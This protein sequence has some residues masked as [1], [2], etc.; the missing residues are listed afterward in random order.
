MTDVL[1]AIVAGYCA[2]LSTTAAI[3]IGIK[4]LASRRNRYH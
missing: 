3:V 1:W 4:V 2:G